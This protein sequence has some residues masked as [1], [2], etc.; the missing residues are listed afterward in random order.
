MSDLEEKELAELIS[1]AQEIGKDL[2]D[3]EDAGD[4]EARAEH[5][6]NWVTFFKPLRGGPYEGTVRRA[7]W[8]AST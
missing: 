3:A 4:Q 6:Q 8:E 2:K 5:R 7:Y 1:E